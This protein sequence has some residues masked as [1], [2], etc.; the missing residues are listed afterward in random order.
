MGFASSEQSARGIAARV[1]VKKTSRGI[2]ALIS[3]PLRSSARAQFQRT[4]EH[5]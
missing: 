4:S 2:A 1:L 5:D 3:A